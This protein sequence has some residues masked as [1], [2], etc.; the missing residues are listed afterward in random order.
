MTDDLWTKE[1]EDLYNALEKY[2]PN[3]DDRLVRMA[4]KHGWS[5]KETIL[6]GEEIDRENQELAAAEQDHEFVLDHD[7]SMNG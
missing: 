4:I 2:L 6:V 5:L 1:H 3:Y 7:H